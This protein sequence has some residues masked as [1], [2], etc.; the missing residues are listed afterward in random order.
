MLSSFLILSIQ[1]YLAGLRYLRKKH[2][3]AM[4]MLLSSLLSGF[5]FLGQLLKDRIQ[6]GVSHPSVSPQ[7]APLQLSATIA[8]MSKG[9]R[10]WRYGFV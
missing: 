6:E 4:P 9:M 2:L 1:Y 10:K 3:A 8:I 7:S 5:C